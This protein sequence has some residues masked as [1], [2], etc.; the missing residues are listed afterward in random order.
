MSTNQT[1]A[2]LIGGQARAKYLFQ[3]ESNN[4]LSFNKGDI[5]TLLRQIDNNWF[6]GKIDNRKG[7]FPISYVEV[8]PIK[9]LQKTYNLLLHFFFR[10]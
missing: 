3:A 7:I 4:E 10:F 9:Y 2:A 6:E 1:H 5:I 8:V